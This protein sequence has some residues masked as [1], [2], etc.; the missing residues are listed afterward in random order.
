MSTHKQLLLDSISL[1]SLEASHDLLASYA[2][3]GLVPLDLK[4][5]DSVWNPCSI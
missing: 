4:V 1:H 5:G 2:D 3:N